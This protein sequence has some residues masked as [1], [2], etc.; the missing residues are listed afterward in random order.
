[1]LELRDRCCRAEAQRDR[2]VSL[3]RSE[4]D[5]EEKEARELYDGVLEPHLYLCRDRVTEA[6]AAIDK[7]DNA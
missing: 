5:A 6:L 7:E 4:L 3:L 1:M 2:L